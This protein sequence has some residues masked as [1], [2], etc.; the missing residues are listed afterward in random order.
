MAAFKPAPTALLTS[1]KAACLPRL[2]ASDRRQ[3]KAN[4]TRNKRN[5]VG[6]RV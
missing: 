6:V 3:V 4:A 2:Y 1:V 5:G